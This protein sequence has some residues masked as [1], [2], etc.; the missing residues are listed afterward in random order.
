MR[1]ARVAARVLLALV[2]LTLAGGVVVATLAHQQGYRAYAVR[3]ASMTPGLPPGDLVI[4]APP[5]GPYV[6]GD[7]ITFAVGTSSG[8]DPVVTHRVLGVEG[9]ELT[10]KGDANP[11]PDSGTRAET[12]VVGEVVQQIPNAGY[13]LVFLQ[14][15]GGL[16]GILTSILALML[17]WSLFF[18]QS[19]EGPAHR[20]A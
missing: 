3:T 17:C 14:Q 5:T 10:T 8:V 2:V 11:T 9:D 6:K 16:L 15:P 20:T 4:D 1:W 18:G 19:S 13:V 7:V 12:D